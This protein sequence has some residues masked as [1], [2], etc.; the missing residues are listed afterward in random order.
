MDDNIREQQRRRLMY[1]DSRNSEQRKQE[2]K[3]KRK[4]PNKQRKKRIMQKD[5]NDQNM[6]DN[7]SE[8]SIEGHSQ[9]NQNS[10]IIRREGEASPSESVNSKSAP[11][12][13]LSII[14]DLEF[15]FQRQPRSVPQ[16]DK[17]S[18]SHS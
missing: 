10:E 17:K 15:G 3:R 13:M 6:I 14:S 11:D 4:R 16:S 5:I 9:L 1:N 18:R 8:I 2:L 12:R 7:I